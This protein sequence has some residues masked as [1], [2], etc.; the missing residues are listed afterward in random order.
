[1][2]ELKKQLEHLKTLLNRETGS[3]QR[4]TPNLKIQ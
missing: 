2:A 3:A 1:M 4:T